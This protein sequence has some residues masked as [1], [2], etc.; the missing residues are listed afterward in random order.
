MNNILKFEFHSRLMLFDGN[1]VH[2]L[3]KLLWEEIRLLKLV[4]AIPLQL[5]LM[6]P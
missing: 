1:I 6:S 2:S 3:G 4:R 5:R